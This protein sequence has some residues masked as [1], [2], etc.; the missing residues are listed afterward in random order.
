MLYLWLKAFHL[1]FVI[2][3][4]AGLFYL[5][6]LFVH[7]AMS[8]DI[9]TRQRLAI[10][11]R[12]L[13]RFVTPLAVLAIV[14]GLLLTWQ[15]WD[16]YKTAGWFHTKV[17]LLVLLIAYHIHCGRIVSNF[18]QEKNLRSHV[19]YR[20]FNELPVFILFAIVILAVVKPY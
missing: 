12:K 17:F 19:F 10:M 18:A 15:N 2:C 3:W 20:I 7:H 4:F 16:Y 1:I 14:C 11:E 5:P 9:A 8:E 13:F 6:R